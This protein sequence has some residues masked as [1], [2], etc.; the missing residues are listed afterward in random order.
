MINSSVIPTKGQQR[1]IDLDVFRGFAVLGIFMVNIL[2]MNT[3]FTFRG[4]WEAEQTSN[5]AQSAFF[6]LETFFYSK[7]FVI[8]SLLFGM[9]VALQIQ[10]AKEKGSFSNLF[11]IRRF[12]SLFLFGALHI[13]FIWSGDILHLYGAYGCLLMLLFRLPAKP[14]LWGSI[15][16]FIFPFYDELFNYFIHF[17][18]DDAHAHLSALP[19]ESIIELKRNGTYWSGLILRI[20]EYAFAADFL[21]GGI[22][23]VALSMMTLGGYFVKK[24]MLQNIEKWLKETGVYLLVC[25]IL[26]MTYRFVLLYYIVPNFEVGPGSFLSFVLMSIYYLSDIALALSYLWVIAYILRIPTLSKILTPL[27]YVGRTAFT[28]YILQSLIGYWIMR[29]FAYYHCF[30]VIECIVLVVLIFS[31]QVIFSKVWLRYFQFGPLE[32]LWR[33]ISYWKLVPLKK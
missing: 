10:R 24:G 21:Y 18:T 27:Q 31:T 20:K 33:C 13:L 16:I 11:F 3:A 22:G 25:V 30:N 9:G 14:L 28:N 19:K 1:I 32:W 12:G 15:L 5:I 17:F 2:V 23:P 6:V 4:E 7:F 26:L 29:T 8:F